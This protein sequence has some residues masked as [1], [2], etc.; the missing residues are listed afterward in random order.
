MKK[1]I[2]FILIL[3]VIS[4]SANAKDL[5]VN[6]SYITQEYKIGN[7]QPSS[8]S[9]NLEN[10]DNSSFQ[11]FPVISSGVSNL[12]SIS[13]STLNFNGISSDN[14][15]LNF[16]IPQNTAPGNY[17]GI[18]QFGS[19]SDE[20]IPININILSNSNCRIITSF[21]NYYSQITTGTSAYDEIFSFKVG[22]GCAG[23]LQITDIRINGAIQTSSGLQP[24]QINKA[25]PTG[26]KEVG[27]LIEVDLK[28]DISKLTNGKYNPTLLVNGIYNDEP[29]SSQIQ[30]TIDVSGSASPHQNFSITTLPSCS[31]QETNLLINKTYNYI[32]NGINDLNLKVN[33]IPNDFLKGIS[34]DAVGSSF[35]WQFQPV[36]NGNTKIQSYFTYNDNFIGNIN[37]NELIITNDG[38][39]QSGTNLKLIFNPALEN[40]DFK[41]PVNIEVR[42]NTSNNIVS[43]AVLFV[44]GENKGN[45]WSLYLEPGKEYK[46]SATADGYNTLDYNLTTKSI[47]LLISISPLIPLVN[48]YVYVST[49]DP[50]TQQEV[51]ATLLLDG[52]SVNKNF[53]LNTDG[54][55]TLTASLPGYVD[56]SINFSSELIPQLLTQPTADE[57]KSG[58][59][60]LQISANSS[61]EVRYRKNDKETDKINAQGNGNII[62]FKLNKNGI[63]SV[64]ANGNSVWI[65]TKE[66]NKKTVLIL[67]ILGSIILI[68]IVILA[69]LYFRKSNKPTF[70]NPFDNAGLE[71]ETL[72]AMP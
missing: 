4:I 42:D 54:V 19:N 7:S 32:C 57:I 20:Q 10:N 62:E 72:K 15:T 47:P 65:Y 27:D 66:V 34:S 49:K 29:I 17:N 40:I 61:W 44:N 69:I 59:I 60:K 70:A 14:L 38:L 28:F 67:S 26:F 52:I 31:P 35:T 30:F 64:F 22:Q 18:I 55:H 11:I 51:N 58:D 53:I 46:I 23:G 25:I 12:V 2:I 48:G 5:S 3:I 36:K 71:D 6:P 33:I 56:S 43:N 63:Y 21:S 1:S 39:A 24:M 45:N 8:I 37:S 50:N 68:V 16:N 13:K 9:I 41:S